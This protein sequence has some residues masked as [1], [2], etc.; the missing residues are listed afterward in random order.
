MPEYGRARKRKSRVLWSMLKGV[1]EIPCRQ[2]K[3]TKATQSYLC[4]EEDSSNITESSKTHIKSLLIRI[5]ILV[6]LHA[7]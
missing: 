7:T 6:F 3:K 4:N 5:H 1:S 2:E